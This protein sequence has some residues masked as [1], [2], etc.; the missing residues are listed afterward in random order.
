MADNKI[1]SVPIEDLVINVNSSKSI[2]NVNSGRLDTIGSGSVYTGQYSIRYR[3]VSEDKNSISEW[4]GVYRVPMISTATLFGTA[5]YPVPVGSSSTVSG[6]KVFK[7]TWTVP[8]V[9]KKVTKY[10]LYVRWGDTGTTNQYYYYGSFAGGLAEVIRPSTIS[11][12]KA[13]FLLQLETDPK[14]V[15]PQAKVFEL[16][17]QSL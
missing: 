16:T 15:I 13:S 5:G 7:M 2:Y 1:I 11:D 6:T 12:N 3:V 10:D 4:S 9:I 8:A 17:Y 14:V